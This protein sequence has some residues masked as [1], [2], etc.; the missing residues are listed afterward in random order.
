MDAT[1]DAD[2]WASRDAAR[3]AIA[4]LIAYDDANKYLEMSSD[5]LRVW[6]ILSEDPAAILMLPAVIAFEKINE[7]ELVLDKVEISDVQ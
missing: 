7:L 6:S 1:R 3:D 4:S 2:W 5:K